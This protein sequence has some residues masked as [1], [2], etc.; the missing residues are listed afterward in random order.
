MLASADNS[1]KLEVFSIKEKKIVFSQCLDE[2]VWTLKFLKG[3]KKL[4][5]G[6]QEGSLI[7]FDLDKK[8]K[9]FQLSAHE[10]RIRTISVYQDFVVSG[11]FDCGV[12]VWNWKN[13]RK[14]KDFLVHSDWVRA[15]FIDQKNVFS[16]ADDSFLCVHVFQEEKNEDMMDFE[17]RLMDQNNEN[18]RKVFE[19]QANNYF[20]KD[21]Q[22]DK[23]DFVSFREIFR[24]FWV[25]LIF[26]SSVSKVYKEIDPEDWKKIVWGTIGIV[27]VGV[28]VGYFTD[29]GWVVLVFFCAVV[30]SMV[31]YFKVKK[32]KPKF[33]SV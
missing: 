1:Y 27:F 30:A 2:K 11:S 26:N 24:N 21:F 29:I 18:H 33:L 28:F 5:C 14:I 31:F 19:C 22:R 9:D 8:S 16:V 10:S 17:D 32:P 20:D 7:C 15:V 4:L 12:S 3:K 25:F 6:D 13:E 23:R